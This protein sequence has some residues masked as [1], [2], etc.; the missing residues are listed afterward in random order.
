M[1]RLKILFLLALSLMLAM[2]LSARNFKKEIMVLQYVRN[3]FT[4][5]GIS[6]A[7][8]TLMRPDSTVIDTIRTRQAGGSHNARA[9][10]YDLER[11][12]QRIIVKV[13]HPEYETHI[14]TYEVNN[15]GRNRSYDLPELFLR[16]KAK[17]QY[18]DLE[19]MLD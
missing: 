6:D 18:R 1:T 9:W 14:G 2:P 4:K 10:F 7:F 11:K 12:S 15:Y 17:D 13:E 5:H 3:S 16:R 19:Q 8:V